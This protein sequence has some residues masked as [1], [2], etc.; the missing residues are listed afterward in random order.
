M[1]F[2]MGAGIDI[3]TIRMNFLVKNKDLVGKTIAVSGW[4]YT[5]TSPNKYVTD[6]M[7]ANQEIVERN[8]NIFGHD[9]NK[10]RFLQGSQ[11]GGKAACH[12]DSGGKKM[13]YINL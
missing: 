4:G 1:P 2:N 13:Q 6:L 5:D 9:L 8:A 7:M 12:M 3:D 11:E 10:E